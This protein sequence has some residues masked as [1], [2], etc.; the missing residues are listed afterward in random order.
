MI[1][2]NLLRGFALMALA[3]GFGLPFLLLLGG[4]ALNRWRKWRARI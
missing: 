3:L 1:N 2:R 4:L